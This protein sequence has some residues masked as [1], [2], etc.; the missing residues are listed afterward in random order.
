MAKIPPPA[1]PAGATNGPATPPPTRPT[2]GLPPVPAATVG[3]LD[4]P[5]P[6]SLKPLNFKVPADFHKDFKS[7]AV[8]QGITMVELLYEAFAAIKDKRGA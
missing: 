7:Y 1:R 8:G 2:K 5:E 4:K 3:N 6:Q